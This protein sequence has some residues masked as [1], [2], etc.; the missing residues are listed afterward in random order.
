LSAYESGQY[1]L[2]VV[3]GV[4]FIGMHRFMFP[5]RARVC[6]ALRYDGSA[7]QKLGADLGGTEMFAFAV[8]PDGTPHM[9]SNGF[10]NAFQQGQWRALPDIGNGYF[11]PI[12]NPAIAFDRTGRLYAVVH[13]PPTGIDGSTG[14]D[15]S[16]I[17]RFNGTS[18]DLLG[19]PLA[20]VQYPIAFGFDATA[21]YVAISNLDTFEHEVRRFNGTTW[22]MV[23]GGTVLDANQQV[24]AVSSAGI[25]YLASSSGGSFSFWQA[26]ATPWVASPMVGSYAGAS[27]TPSIDVASDD[28]LHVAY[29]TDR[30]PG[31]NI[32]PGPLV[33]RLSGTQLQDLSVAGLDP[34]IFGIVKLKVAR[35]GSRDVPYI[36][37]ETI[38]TLIV[39][40]LE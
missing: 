17:A 13:Q 21:P 2:A 27:A 11:I 6:V 4:P 12:G 38:N 16:V 39:K 20:S 15:S 34:S 31:A 32:V 28:A 29:L 25:A 14:T 40:K 7:W 36:A 37:Y 33:A 10:V 24:F 3:G 26:G 18:W 23:G 22:N 30:D 35:V 1:E 5:G 19:G 8:S 9:V